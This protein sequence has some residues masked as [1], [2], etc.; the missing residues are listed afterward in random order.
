MK[1]RISV[2]TIFLLVGQFLFSQSKSEIIEYGDNAFKNEN[3][4][5]AAYFYKKILDK[6][7]VS[8][9]LVHPYEA[10]SWIAPPKRT[11]AE[12]D[13]IVET[14]KADTNKYKGD[15]E[16]VHKLAL[17][18]HKNHDYLLAE[19]WY[20]IAMSYKID[21]IDEELQSSK[22]WYGE[23][24]MK[25]GKYDEAQVQFDEF[26]KETPNMDYAK[27]ADKGIIGCFYAQDPSSDNPEV[28]VVLADTNMNFG[29]S[30][31]GVNYFGDETSVIFSAAG[32]GGVVEDEKTQESIYLSDFYISQKIMDEG[33]SEAT[34]FNPP[35][36]SPNNE[37]AGVLS[38][39]RTTFY[40]T[41]QSGVNNKEVA[42]WVS[43]NFNNQW[44]EPLKLDNKVNAEGFKSMHP[45]L[46]LD[47][48]V[49]YF[50]SNRPG[51][52]G[53]MDIWYCNIDEYGGL[54]E[55]I[56]MGPYVNS[57]GDDVTPY[58]NY[59]TK[60]LYFSS[61]AL[62]GLGGLD[63]YK[64]TYNE[65]EESWSN[66]KNIGKPFNSNKDD[67][68]FII[69]KEQKEG[70]LSSDRVPCDC[71]E[72]YEGSVYCYKIYT[73]GQP[74]MK[75]SLS[76]TAFNAETNEIIPNA[77]LTFK[78]VRGKMDP[79]FITTDEQG[80]YE[81]KLEV[82]WELFIKAQ[83]AKF[84]GDAASL[85]TK[86]LTESKHFVQD[87]F[88][89]PIPLGEIEIPGIEYD[90]DAATLRPKSKEILDQLVEFLELNNNLVIEIRS[91]TDSRGND[92]YN[93]KLSDK[94]AASVV[95]Y[96]VA[97]GIAKERLQSIGMGEQEPL[98]DCSKY[99]DC[100]E[101]G[102]ED[103]DCH[104]KNRRTAFKTLSEDF[105]DVFKG[106]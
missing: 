65:D 75:Y 37:G 44:L 76:G 36:N 20:A 64:T 98:D 4:A 12:R 30:S 73:F 16:V 88:L 77:L 105:K 38:I 104:Q 99:E 29:T 40:F 94:R 15:E 53:G 63:I 58:Y 71:G 9:G 49:L 85:S 72:E 93:L 96:L 60:T 17:S 43:K 80:N 79:V 2:V 34:N 70:Y 86:G 74:E 61:D 50:S 62:G 89:T 81:R 84:F 92:D 106:E 51:G 22:L 47:G 24:L 3:Y 57:V 14:D 8:S 102:K 101:T 11:K 67:A 26:K 83:K 52:H 13:S 91:H 27:R 45:A 35:I 18:Y 5:S 56:N 28:D 41:R 90:F 78:D 59:F 1:L 54:S 23:A 7:G 68:Y 39:D 48:D 66:P 31:Y 10:R 6:K 97:H 32:P 82:G 46:S 87:F 19:E 25:N 33:F 95:K 103:C 42:I 21:V 69:D 100:G 55:P